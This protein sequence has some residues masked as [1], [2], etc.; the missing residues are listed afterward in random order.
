[1]KI[2]VTKKES[3]LLEFTL[4]GERHTFANLL[5][6]RLVMDADVDF[7][8]YKLKYP[9]DDEAEFVLKTKKKDPKKVLL[10]ACTAIQDE[11]SD[12]ESKIKKAIK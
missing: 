12:F 11:L 2:T 9:L 6:T 3:N 1:M 8:S 10:D 5:K 7:V 4:K